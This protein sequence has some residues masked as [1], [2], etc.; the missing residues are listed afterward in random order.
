VIVQNWWE[1]FGLA[2]R[3]EWDFAGYAAILTQAIIVFMLAAVVF[4][5]AREDG[6]IDLTAHYEAER[7]SIYLIAIAY[8]IS[9]PIRALIV[10]KA[11]LPTLDLIFHAVFLATFFAL[12]FVRNSVIVIAILAAITGSFIYYIATFTPVLA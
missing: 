1:T 10:D 4:P 12:I 9:S 8:V 11:L 7:R 5:N 3:A 6:E 2:G